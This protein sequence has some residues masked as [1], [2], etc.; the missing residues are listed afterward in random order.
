[1]GGIVEGMEEAGGGVRW[2]VCVVTAEVPQLAFGRSLAASDDDD[3]LQAA[4]P[5]SW[6]SSFGSSAEGLRRIVVFLNK[7]HS[8]LKLHM[9]NHLF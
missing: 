1:M 5:D 3:R 7:K 4:V 9:Y 6:S 8:S 2:C